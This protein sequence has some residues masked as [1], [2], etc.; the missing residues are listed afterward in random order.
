[1]DLAALKGTS[2]VDDMTEAV[3]PIV[4][5]IV[6][7]SGTTVDGYSMNPSMNVMVICPQL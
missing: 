5:P 1:M 2:L 7:L 4:E 3:R 6:L